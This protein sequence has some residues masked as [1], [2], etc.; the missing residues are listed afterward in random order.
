MADLNEV[1]LIGTIKE[2]KKYDKVTRLKVITKNERFT[3]SHTVVAF[4]DNQSW[5]IGYKPGDR[6]N[7]WGE[8]GLNKYKDAWT[9]QI[10]LFQVDDKS[11]E[12]KGSQPPVADDEGGY[13]NDDDDVPL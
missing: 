13:I 1:H 8:I 9:T 7:L 3:T 12:F 5:L 11:E 6:I 10:V 2:M 4:F